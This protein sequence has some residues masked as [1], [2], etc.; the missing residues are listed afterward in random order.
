MKDQ[1]LKVGDLGIARY[2]DYSNHQMSTNIGSPLYQSPE[3]LC[4]GKYTKTCDIYALGVTFYELMALKL[5]FIAEFSMK[6]LQK[7]KVA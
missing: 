3:M 6:K 1:T 5:P 4:S 7:E 2:I